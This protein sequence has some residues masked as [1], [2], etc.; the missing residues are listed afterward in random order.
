MMNQKG[1]DQ[2]FE[3][4]YR[5]DERVKS[6]DRNMGEMK[7]D[8]VEVKKKVDDISEKAA[9]DR[10]R[11]SEIDDEVKMAKRVSWGAIASAFISFISNR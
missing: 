9:A 1:G 7:A 6:I 2:L 4:L 10:A 8:L 3:L 5:I 11:L